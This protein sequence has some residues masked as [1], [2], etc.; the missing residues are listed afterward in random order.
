MSRYKGG[1]TL[2]YIGDQFEFG[3]CPNPNCKQFNKP[4]R[5]Q[6]SASRHFAQ[7]LKKECAR[8]HVFMELANESGETTETNDEARNQKRIKL[9][10][11]DET[12]FAK[13]P[14]IFPQL[15]TSTAYHPLYS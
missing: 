4:F 3:A 9:D 5:T 8:I 12:Q 6:K 11:P 7:P 10:M 2:E 13:A 1:G 14:P 15:F